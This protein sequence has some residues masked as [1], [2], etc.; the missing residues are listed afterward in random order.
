MEKLILQASNIKCAGCV[1]NIETHLIDYAGIKT[2]NVDIET[3]QLTIDGDE[4]DQ[5]AI[6]NKLTEIGYPII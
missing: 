4:L 2:V 5:Q 1:S 6:K 3:N